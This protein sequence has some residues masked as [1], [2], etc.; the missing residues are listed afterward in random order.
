MRVALIGAVAVLVG[1]VVWVS[2]G[3]DAKG[4]IDDAGWWALLALAFPVVMG[5]LAWKFGEPYRG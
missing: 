5:L 1:T 3:V 2:V 4:L